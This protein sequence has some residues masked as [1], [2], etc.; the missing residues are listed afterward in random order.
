MSEPNYKHPPATGGSHSG[1]QQGVT[2]ALG[3]CIPVLDDQITQ[4]Y[5]KKTWGFFL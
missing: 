4:N 5:R 3:R 1:S 2:E